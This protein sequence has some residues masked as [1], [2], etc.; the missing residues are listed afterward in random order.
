MLW[1]SRRTTPPSAIFENQVR[2]PWPWRW[3][4]WWQSQVAPGRPHK[5]R[6][7]R[8]ESKLFLLSLWSENQV[9]RDGIAAEIL[10]SSS[11]EQNE[12][13]KEPVG[14]SHWKKASHPHR[15]N[16]RR[17]GRK[18]DCQHKT[19]ARFQLKKYYSPN[20]DDPLYQPDLLTLLVK[21]G[22]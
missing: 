9:L 7:H 1:N 11:I 17:W 8:E 18:A 13:V 19:G 15:G 22:D 12:K 6:V 3:R 10:P 16:R 21:R 2:W 5:K 20:L 4:M 14:L